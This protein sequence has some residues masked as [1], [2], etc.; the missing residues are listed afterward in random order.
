MSQARDRL[1]VR[2]QRSDSITP[3]KAYSRIAVTGGAQRVNIQPQKHELLKASI[4][5]E[6]GGSARCNPN[7][8]FRVET[9]KASAARQTFR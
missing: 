2:F 6:T 4:Q 3:R 8:F 5:A 7:N 9:S 1:M